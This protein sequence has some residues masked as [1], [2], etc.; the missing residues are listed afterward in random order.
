METNATIRVMIVDDQTLFSEGLKT[1]LLSRADDLDVVGTCANGQ[2]A[3]ALADTLHPDIILMDVRMPV[4]DGVEATKQIHRRHPDI[5]IVMLTTFDDDEYV[6]TSLVHGA[7]GYLLKNRPPAELIASIR[8]VQNGVLQIDPAVSKALIHDVRFRPV[9]EDDFIR[10][11]TTLTQR[12]REV[13][14]L[15]TEAHPNRAI[16]KRLGIAEQTVRNYT[17]LIFGKLGIVNRLEI[18]RY[19]EKIQYYL[20]HY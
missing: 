17:S 18:L 1:I 3:I 6:K 5:R 19:T 7:I 9:D 15:L 13:L 10:N 16:A 4:M 8:A 20:E 12:E 14:E 11:L 2:E